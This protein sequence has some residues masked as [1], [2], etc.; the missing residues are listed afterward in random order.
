M[1]AEADQPR[2]R[3]STDVAEAIA[4]SRKTRAQA[5]ATVALSR[6]MRA[7]ARQ[8]I[9]ENREQGRA[10]NDRAATN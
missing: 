3:L 8:V 1:P 6:A 7:R 4:F 9:Q 10:A 5:K 2:H